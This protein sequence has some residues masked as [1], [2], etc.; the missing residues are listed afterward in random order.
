MKVLKWGAAGAAAIGAL[1]LGAPVAGAAVAT[2]VATP[3]QSA[4]LKAIPCENWTLKIA[5]GHASGTW[6]NNYKT[7][8]GT[9]TDDKADGRCPYVRSH[10]SNGGVSDSA[11]IGPKGASR[12]FT[13]NAP[14][15]TTSTQVTIHYVFC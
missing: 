2:D 12:S 9:V 15:G 5:E 8:S 7:V 10:W 1:A 13:L 3:S 11:S 14:S 6:C 4:Q